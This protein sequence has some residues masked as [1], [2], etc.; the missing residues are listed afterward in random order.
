MGVLKKKK[1]TSSGNTPTPKTT[2]YVGYESVIGPE[3]F[4]EYTAHP[5]KHLTNGRQMAYTAASLPIEGTSGMV[6]GMPQHL[7]NMGV[8]IKEKLVPGASGVQEHY[9]F[10]GDYT[11]AVFG[12]DSGNKDAGSVLTGST[13]GATVG[14]LFEFMDRAKTYVNDFV[15]D[16]NPYFDQSAK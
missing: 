11:D 16:G 8:E 9:N 14:R 2:D 15:Y 6:L 5:R 3:E 13:I 1:K 10:A 4:R 7:M 12:K